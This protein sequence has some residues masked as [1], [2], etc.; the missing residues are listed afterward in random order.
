VNGGN[1]EREQVAVTALRA[2]MRG[3]VN[4]LEN[5]RDR[6][7]FLGGECDSV[8]DMER[9]DPHLDEARAALASL[10]ALPGAK[11]DPVDAFLAEVRA[12]IIRARTKFPG[13]RVMTVALAEEF[14]ELAKAALDE[15]AANVRVE[16]VQT[17]AM[18]ARLAIDGDASLVD[19]RASRGLDQLG[20]DL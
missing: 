20:V 10:G 2:L 8:E 4:T 6:I 17:A 13:S 18:A 11:V 15:P 14:G 1:V 9:R 3:Y 16:A 7:L 5:G 19:W 12:E